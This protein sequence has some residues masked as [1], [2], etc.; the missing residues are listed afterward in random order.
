MI[1]D[2]H[3]WSNELV[4]QFKS[5]QMAIP[6]VGLR[7]CAQHD[8]HLKVYLFHFHNHKILF[9]CFKPLSSEQLL[10]HICFLHVKRGKHGFFSMH[11]II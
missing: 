2:R 5:I 7:L 3:R 9:S 8:P 4:P 11:Y 10:K 6:V 1:P